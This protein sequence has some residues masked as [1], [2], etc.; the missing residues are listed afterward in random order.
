MLQTA[1]EILYFVHTCFGIQI[2]ERRVSAQRLGRL[3]KPTPRRFHIAFEQPQTGE[4]SRCDAVYLVAFLE[5]GRTLRLLMA[6]YSDP[7]TA[8]NFD[9]P[10]GAF[11]AKWPYPSRPL[12]IDTAGGTFEGVGYDSQDQSTT[13]RGSWTE[14]PGDC[15]RAGHLP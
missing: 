9:P 14:H 1:D 3:S 5:S 4:I 10:P 7:P 8:N 11:R 6:I 2:F 12:Y 13:Q 15:P